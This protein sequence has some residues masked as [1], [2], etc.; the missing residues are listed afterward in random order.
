MNR[1]KRSS[2]NQDSGFSDDLFAKLRV[3]WALSAT[4]SPNIRIQSFL[5]IPWVKPTLRA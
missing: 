5:F 1:H 3:A 4:F 2:E